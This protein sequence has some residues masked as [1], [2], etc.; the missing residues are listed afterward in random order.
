FSSASARALSSIR[1]ICS[2]RSSTVAA[3]A[4]VPPS[5]TNAMT[6]VAP[7]VICLTLLVGHQSLELIKKTLAVQFSNNA[8]VHEIGGFFVLEERVGESHAFKFQLHRFF[9]RV[10]LD[11]YPAQRSVINDIEP[12]TVRDLHLL[13][14][15]FLYQRLIPFSERNRFA[16]RHEKS[17]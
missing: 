7:K 10:R 2:N 6:T 16:A 3:W 9:A 14:D 5:I 11:R 13:G 4:T 12:S 1:L 8:A 15:H 17:P